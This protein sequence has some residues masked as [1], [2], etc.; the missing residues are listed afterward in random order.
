MEDEFWINIPLVLFA[1]SFLQFL[2]LE[3]AVYDSYITTF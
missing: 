1:S 2:N 3:L